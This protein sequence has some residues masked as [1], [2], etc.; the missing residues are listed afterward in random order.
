MGLILCRLCVCVLCPMRCLRGLDL[1]NM[2]DLRGK[3]VTTCQVS[4]EV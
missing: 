1:D 4:K 2:V 3:M